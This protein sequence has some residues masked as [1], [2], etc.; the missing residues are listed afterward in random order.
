MA[1]QA[2][3]TA[4]DLVYPLVGILADPFIEDLVPGAD[5]D[6]LFISSDLFTYSDLLLILID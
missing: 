4:A 6:V 5:T 1:E 3:A 2:G